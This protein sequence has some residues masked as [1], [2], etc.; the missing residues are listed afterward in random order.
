MMNNM[1]ALTIANAAMLIVW[2]VVMRYLRIGWRTL[3]AM[4]PTP[5][6]GFASSYGV[7]AFNAHFAPSWVAFAMAAAY[8]LTYVGLASYTALNEKQRTEGQKISRDAA[9]ISFIQNGLAGL[10]YV[11]P[12]VMGYSEWG[13]KALFINVPLAALHA[14]QV[15]I[16]YRTANFTLH[17]VAITTENKPKVVNVDK[18]MEI[19]PAP[20]VDNTMPKVDKRAK[21][22]LEMHEAG[23]TYDAISESL[24]GKPSK[25]YINKHVAMYR[26]SLVSEVE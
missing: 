23:M 5:M 21:G 15:W 1:I 26:D 19:L 8:E 20:Q 18:T 3:L 6:L 17:G 9:S 10:V 22:W 12:A 13:P 11:Q 24:G 25:Q 14:A 7:Y 16:A 4:L 2:F